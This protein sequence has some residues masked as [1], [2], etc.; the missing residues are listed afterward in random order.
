MASIYKRPNGK[1]YNVIY[2]VTDEHGKR[3]QVWESGLSYKEAKKRK[4]EIE[5]QQ[6]NGSFAEPN[7]LTVEAYLEQ[8]LEYYKKKGNSFSTCTMVEGCLRNHVIPNL[9]QQLLQELTPKEVEDFFLGL[10]KQRHLQNNRYIL[11]E[12]DDI[13]YLSQNTIRHIYVYFNMALNKAVEWKLLVKNPIR[14]KPP[15]AE[16]NHRAA[17]DEE[18]L[19]EAPEEIKDPMAAPVPASGLCRLHAFGGDFRPDLGPRRLGGGE[20]LH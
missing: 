8:W 13:P 3:K 17:W 11:W 7:K 1:T 15:K 6:E 19:L 10:K 16:A 5:A 12:E 18:T 20:R 9:G 4:L 14:I 2:D